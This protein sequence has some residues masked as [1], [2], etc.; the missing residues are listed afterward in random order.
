LTIPIMKADPILVSRN[1]GSTPK[2]APPLSR[3]A[4]GL[5]ALFAF[6]GCWLQF[7]ILPFAPVVPW[8]D[9]AL[10]LLDGV[11]IA[12]GQVPYRDFA[13]IVTPGTDYVYATL[14]LLFGSRAWL[15]GVTMACLAAAIAVAMTI[16]ARR[17]L[18]GWLAAVPALLFIGVVVPRAAYPTHH[19]FSTLAVMAAALLL[20]DQP[21]T[22]RRIAGAGVLCGVAG[23]FTQTRFLFGLAA[24][25][26]LFLWEGRAGSRL[27]RQFWRKATLFASSAAL[28]MTAGCAYF[29]GSAGPARLWFSLVTFPLRYYTVESF[30]NWRVLI[31]TAHLHMGAVSWLMLLFLYATVP[32]SYVFFL[33][34]RRRAQLRPSTDRALMLM[35]IAGGVM[36]LS[37]ASAPS[38][39]R[40]SAASPPALVLLVVL[41]A[42]IRHLR[43]VLGAGIASAAI[44]LI[45]LPVARQMRWHQ[46]F[47]TPAG[48]I[49]I[50]DPKWAEEFDWSTHHISPGAPFF[51]TPTVGYAFHMAHP[52]QLSFVLPSD[53]TRPEQV[54]AMLQ[55]FATAQPPVMIIP[56]A[57]LRPH[58]GQHSDHLGP[59][60][61]YLQNNYQRTKVFA[62]S[63]ELWERRR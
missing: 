29:L 34:Y 35:T 44:L 4:V 59:F 26:V 51:G 19:W 20:I 5:V 43:L 6:T 8:G 57:Y 46:V 50:V 27:D 2:P 39:L 3:W 62:S 25:V 52:A 54:D 10:F 16:V 37:I 7:F 48:R 17:M 63:D 22:S 24:F 56:G 23:L 40:M 11:K 42:E 18:A 32:L 1:T 9:E 14:V 31:I 13:Q 55:A 33:M 58:E 21:S 53:Y 45:A 60:R 36:F 41:L 47:D 15:P 49:A 12:A 30:N 38:W 61:T 28:I